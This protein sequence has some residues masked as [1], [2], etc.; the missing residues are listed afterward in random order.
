RARRGVGHARGAAGVRR[1]L[2]VAVPR[3]TGPGGGGVA[4]ASEDLLGNALDRTLLRRIFACVWP[5]RGRLLIAAALLPLVAVLE[6]VQP[7]LLKRA[8]DEHIA[9][10]AT[11]GPDRRRL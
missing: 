4:M 1:D 7:A 11:D 5:Y 6:G 3:A 8:I 9:V 2:S 10:R